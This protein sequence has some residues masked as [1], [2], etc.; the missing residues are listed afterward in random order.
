MSRDTHSLHGAQPVQ[1]HSLSSAPVGATHSRAMP[2]LSRRQMVQAAAAMPLLSVLA[3]CA[4]RAGTALT[5]A[6][7]WGSARWASGGT[8]A[9]SA[10]ARS[11][12][13]FTA[14]GTACALTCEATI[15]PCHTA[16]PERADVSDGWDGLPVHMVLRVLDTQCQPVAG[17]L[18]EIWH[19]NYTGGYSGEIVAMCN[20]HPDDV[21]KQFF[22]GYQRTDAQGVVRF[23]TCYPGWYHGR[24]NHVHLRI[25]KGDYDANDRAQAWSV[26]QLLFPDA[27]NQ[28]IFANQPL[29]RDKGQA[30]TSLDADNV[31]GNE[32][33]KAPYLFEIHN[34]GGVMVASKTLTI[35]TSLD[36]ASCHAS[37][38][39]PGGFPGGPG[40]RRGPPPG[41]PADGLPGPRG[42]AP[43]SRKPST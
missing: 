2:G 42:M 38:K 17:A 12:N 9:I 33:D 14:A 20:N 6:Q 25:M 15:G 8:A 18:V 1:P 23:D 3:G 19:T 40:G 36:T 4:S 32:P 28:S 34:A 31:V 16:S 21:R 11:L 35:R 13:P 41:F 7:Q 5:T 26:T 27:L 22:R 24:A 10:A 30:D 43:F 37:G 39:M 29:Y